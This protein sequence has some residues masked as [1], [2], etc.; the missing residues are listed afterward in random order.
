MGTAESL[1]YVA[2]GRRRVRLCYVMIHSIPWHQGLGE[3]RWLGIIYRHK[4][5]CLKSLSPS[6]LSLTTS[7]LPLLE[8]LSILPLPLLPV[9]TMIPS[10]LTILLVIGTR[11]VCL[12][13]SSFVP[14]CPSSY[15]PLSTPLLSSP[16][17]G[18]IAA[19]NFTIQRTSITISVMITSVARV[20]TICA[21]HASGRIVVLL[22]QS[23]TTS[24]VTFEAG[25]P[26]F[27]HLP[28]LPMSPVHTPLKPH[29]CEVCLASSKFSLSFCLFP[30]LDL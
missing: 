9:T 25:L 4:T 2:L 14:F 10:F 22:V 26:L 29:A 7:C 24:L 30:L 11:M 18:L 17:F 13:L 16:V 15:Q 23:A 1:T 21:S 12:S 8:I 5:S 6:F 20:Q 19:R 28:H 27:L 3:D